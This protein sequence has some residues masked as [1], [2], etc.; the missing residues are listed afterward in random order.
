MKL[1]WIEKA[2]G[3]CKQTAL[4]SLKITS[5]WGKGA[6]HLFKWN[7]FLERLTKAETYVS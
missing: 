5:N 7:I 4:D 3:R 1:L 2:L 6:L